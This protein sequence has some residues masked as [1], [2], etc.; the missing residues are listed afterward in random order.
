MD[1]RLF[2]ASLAL[3]EKSDQDLQGHQLIASSAKIKKQRRAKA[4]RRA[5]RLETQGLRSRASPP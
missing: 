5:P 1:E 4:A 3:F 2:S